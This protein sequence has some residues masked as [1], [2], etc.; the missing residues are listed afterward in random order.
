MQS[1]Q[2]TRSRQSKKASSSSWSSHPPVAPPPALRLTG[3]S[4]PSVA[5]P[6]SPLL[7]PPLGAVLLL[8]ARL[9]LGWKSHSS[10][11]PGPT[12]GGRQADAQSSEPL[13]PFAEISHGHATVHMAVHCCLLGWLSACPPS[14]GS[15]AGQS[16]GR[17]HRRRCHPVPQQ[18][19]RSRHQWLRL[20]CFAPQMAAGGPCSDGVAAD[21]CTT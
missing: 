13:Y 5:V 11:C 8:A 9:R 17:P 21:R 15:P 10:M 20:S 1:G 4:G 3:D 18:R 6:S 16:E 7:P 12:C 19:G 14:V 2:R